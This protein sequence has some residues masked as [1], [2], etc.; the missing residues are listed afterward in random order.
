MMHDRRS[1]ATGTSAGILAAT[2]RPAYECLPALVWTLTGIVIVLTSARWEASLLVAAP[3]FSM[4]LLRFLAAARVLRERSALAGSAITFVAPAALEKRLASAAGR[5]AVWFGTGFDWQPEHAQKLYELSKIDVSRLVPR[6]WVRR[7]VGCGAGKDPEAIG[8]AALDGIE[9]R[10]R[11]LWVTEKTLE[12]GTL[13]VGTTQAGKGVLLSLLVTQAV[14]RGDT[15]IVI[16]PKNSAR[17]KDAVTVAARRAGRSK[18]FFF[19]PGA[20]GDI[21]INPLAQFE[22]ATELASRITGVM[23]EDGPFTAFA[24]SAVHTACALLAACGK[25]PTIALVRDTLTGGLE[26]QLLQAMRRTWSPQAV[27]MALADAHDRGQTGRSAV[28]A[29]YEDWRKAG[30]AHEAVTGAYNVLTHDPVHYAKITASLMPVLDMLSSGSLRQAL[31]PNDDDKDVRPQSTLSQLIDANAVLYVCLNS[32]PD[33][34]VASA[35]GSILLADLAGCAGQRYNDTAKSRHRVSLFVDECSN[36]INRAL[37][38]ILNKGAESGIRTTCAMQTVSDL[39]AR[40]GSNEEARMALGNFNSLICLRTKDRVTQDFVAETFGQTYIATSGAS[41][42]SGAA[43][44]RPGEFTASFTEVVASDRQALIPTD[45]L[46]KLPNCEF[47]ASL[48]GGRLVKGR[49]PILDL[50]GE[51]S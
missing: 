36:V 28:A 11:D 4:A 41:V 8:L 31:S 23:H 32:L 27:D 3:A 26:E 33:P 5:D 10:K 47:F 46:G 30:N 12:G 42:S 40:L 49:V 51:K 6:A 21:R 14:L 34:T 2:W 17:L 44:D 45:M 13:I 48:A 50:S 39:A 38:E 15:V 37:I 7:L 16:D 19:Y 43:P 29:V 35:I 20:A 22:R 24:W 9:K 18:P 25:T 1:N